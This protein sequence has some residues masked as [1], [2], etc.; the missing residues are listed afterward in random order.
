MEAPATLTAEVWGKVDAIRG[1]LSFPAASLSWRLIHEQNRLYIAGDILEIG[2]FK[3]KY[4]ALLASAS[5]GVGRRVVGVDGFF[6]GFQ[7]PL[8]DIWVE[9][10]RTEMIAN[11]E[12]V[13]PLGGLLRIVK[14]D[15]TTLSQA[16]LA[17]ELNGKIAFA[18]I[19][20]GHDASEVYHDLHIVVPSL[21]PGAIIAADDVFN[22]AVPGVAE[23]VCRFLGSGEGRDLSPFAICGNKLFITTREFH[24]AYFGFCKELISTASEGFLRTTR[25]HDEAN[26]KIG[27]APRFFGCK[28][29]P[30]LT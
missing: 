15:T 10:A 13:C 22:H 12:G 11:V 17:Q 24:A 1:W 25:D 18:S 9:P 16:S 23:G 8:Q 29:V 27:W 3:G 14:A 28:V 6:A 7:R 20:A 21:V 4:L 2:V 19:D 26:T 5:H 30:F